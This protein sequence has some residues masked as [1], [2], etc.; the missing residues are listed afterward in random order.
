VVFGKLLNHFVD[1]TA[2]T[3]HPQPLQVNLR[4]RFHRVTP[5][6][7][8]SVVAIE[9]TSQVASWLFISRIILKNIALGGKT[10]QFSLREGIDQP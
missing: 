5:V 8:R 2:L 3:G 7:L 4:I 6:S 10:A 9:T 1:D